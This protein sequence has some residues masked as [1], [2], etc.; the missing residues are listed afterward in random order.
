MSKIIGVTVGTTISPKKLKED[1]KPVLSVNSAK[2]DENG[3]VEIT[4]ELTEE[5]KAA[6]KG[7]KG[8]KGDTGA[9]GPQGPQGP[10]GEKGETGNSGVY[11]GP[12]DMPEDCNVQI[13]PTG[14]AISGSFVLCTEQT[15][16]DEQKAQ[17]RE[18]IEAVSS[19]E[20]GTVK[21]SISKLSNN[22]IIASGGDSE[23]Y[24]RKWSD[25]FAECW[26]VYSGDVWMESYFTSNDVAA[27]D[28]TL[29]IIL[30]SVSNAF[31]TITVECYNEDGDGITDVAT[32]VYWEILDE[33]TL[34]LLAL[35]NTKNVECVFANVCVYTSGYWG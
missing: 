5:Q 28:I 19:A 18:N 24:W 13:D 11:V 9:Q 31:A 14:D 23:C 3:N 2:P 34:H 7:E 21:D 10:Q 26:C 20:L 33:N 17:A 12:G 29:P 22:I 6:L 25:G 32:P 1:L 30:T 35:P 15:L 4:V 8:D 27:I 16:T